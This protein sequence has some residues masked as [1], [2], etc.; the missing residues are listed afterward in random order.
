MNI[1]L[2]ELEWVYSPLWLTACIALGL[3]AALHLY[4]KSTN[5][6]EIKPWQ[7]WTMAI[8]RAL[9][10][11]AIAALLLSPIIKLLQSHTERKNVVFLQD[12]SASLRAVHD[13]VLLA[14]FEAQSENM[15]QSLSESVNT[16]KFYFDDES[17][18]EGP[19]T[20]NGRTTDISNALEQIKEQY[21]ADRLSA[22]VLATDGIYN[23][24]QNPYYQAGL[25]RT[26][27]YIVAMGDTTAGA[28]AEVQRVFHNRVVFKGDEFEVEADVSASGLKNS[29]GQVILSSVAGGQ[30]NRIAS[31]PLR[32][33][34]DEYFR[35]LTFKLKASTAGVSR[36]RISIPII[37][38]ESNRSNNYKDFFVEVIESRQK[39]LLLAHAPHPDLNALKIS[40]EG[41]KNYDI[42]IQ[43]AKNATTNFREYDLV[44]FHNL[45]SGKYPV[46][47]AFTSLSS[48][49]IP[50]LFIVGSKTDIR[51][52]NRAQ[53]VVTIQQSQAQFTEAEPSFSTNFNLFSVNNE[54][55]QFSRSLPPL[56]V[57][58]GSYSQSAGFDV[59]FKQEIKNIETTYPLVVMGETDGNKKGVIT[60]EGLWKWRMFDYAQNQT[61]E[62]SDEIIAKIFQYMA[63]A[64]DRRRFK[65]DQDK[66]IYDENDRIFLSAEY[67]NASYE[68]KNQADVELKL[69]NE[70]GETSSFAF[71]KTDNAYNLDLGKLSPGEYKYTGS[72]QD[73]G[74]RYNESGRFT[75]R[76]L[77]AE[78]QHIRADHQLLRN[79][80]SESGGKLY[81]MN[82]LDQLKT[83]LAASNLI[84]PLYITDYDRT[85]ILNIKWL[86]ALILLFLSAEWFM[87]KY[88]GSY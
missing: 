32:I 42:D 5:F 2:L 30:T 16:A 44:V 10:V 11:A 63:V 35:T 49:K 56:H 27:L 76:A 50:A 53:N 6:A 40:L 26:P 80:A 84:K 36:Y 82:Q 39:V 69:T 78:L 70:S 54:V 57:P 52:F 68:S 51:A 37:D 48:L 29:G 15:L 45:P 3:L 60:G 17:S 38:G 83:D 75:V 81:A 62:R 33:D 23:E 13:T 67:Y 66:N 28:D 22:I 20:F 8:L 79:L 87:R 55:R 41:L 31:Q 86:L 61:F 14:D 64:G 88:L 65:I 7:R 25:E 34:K 21:A 77:V 85:S 72:I 4:Y 9:T 47:S 24:G 58:F 73:G 71:S 43:Y 18:R 46:T 59:L 12:N 74:Q 19:A 1:S